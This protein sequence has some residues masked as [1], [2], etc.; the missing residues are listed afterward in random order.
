M[1]I[2]LQDSISFVMGHS[3]VNADVEL[4]GMFCAYALDRNPMLP[5]IYCV[6]QKPLKD[7][8]SYQCNQLYEFTG[9]TVIE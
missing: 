3:L 9:L 7:I 8:R 1:K 5:L 2:N 6:W 4:L